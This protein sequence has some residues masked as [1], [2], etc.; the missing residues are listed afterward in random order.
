M[1]RIDIL[2]QMSRT[3]MVSNR[4]NMINQRT[5]ITTS[6]AFKKTNPSLPNLATPEE[7]TKKT[8]IK[9]RFFTRMFEFIGGYS[10]K[11]LSTVL[12][13]VAMKAVKTFSNGTRALYGDMKQYAWVNNILSRARDWERACKSL[14]RRQLEVK[15]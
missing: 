12:P 8:E 2:R 13:E 9:K 11:V 5:L 7:A 14:S 1:A 15:L 6:V 3:V 4:Q 10:E